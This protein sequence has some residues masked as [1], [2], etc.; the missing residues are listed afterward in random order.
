MHALQKKILR[1]GCGTS[2][3]R[4]D[5]GEGKC[6][7]NGHQSV[8][9]PH[10]CMQD[11]GICD[12][13]FGMVRSSYRAR[14][15]RDPPASRRGG[16]AQGAL[17]SPTDPRSTRAAYACMSDS[18]YL[19]LPVTVTGGARS[20]GGSGEG[21]GEGSTATRVTCNGPIVTPSEP[22]KTCPCLCTARWGCPDFLPFPPTER[23]RP[24]RSWSV[25]RS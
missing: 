6:D 25:P 19:P 3:V 13:G 12:K 10:G 20:A 4:M 9:G 23:P 1:L 5:G 8:G 11:R 15:V 17:P 18:E 7:N 22:L 24:P 21:P 2:K 16:G 14:P